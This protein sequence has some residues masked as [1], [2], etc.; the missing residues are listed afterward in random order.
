MSTRSDPLARLP[1]IDVRVGRAN[2]LGND[3][4]YRRLLMMFRA[5]QHD[6]AAQFRAARASGDTYA[7]LRLAHTLKS[8][9]GSLGAA[10]LQQSADVLEY[11]CHK[12]ADSEFIDSLVDVVETDLEPVISGLMGLDG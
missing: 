4:L 9:A 6:F 3:R 12:Q 2:T 10:S 7:A 11:A 8:V 5:E 1:G